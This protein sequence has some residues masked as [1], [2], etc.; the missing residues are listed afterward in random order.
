MVEHFQCAFE[1]IFFDT[2]SGKNIIFFIALLRHHHPSF[3][4]ERGAISLPPESVLTLAD[5]VY[6][7]Y[8]ELQTDQ[9]NERKI[10][11]ALLPF[12]NW[13]WNNLRPNVL[14]AG[15]ASW[16]IS[17]Y[18]TTLASHTH[19]NLHYSARTETSNKRQLKQQFLWGQRG[20]CSILL[21]LCL[22]FGSAF[23]PK[24]RSVLW[25]AQV[26]KDI[27]ERGCSAECMWRERTLQGGCKR[28]G[29][30][31]LLMTL[32]S[33]DEAT[34]YRAALLHPCSPV[35]LISFL[36]TC[37]VMKPA[38]FVF[39]PLFLTSHTAPLCWCSVA[40][41]SGAK[42]KLVPTKQKGQGSSWQGFFVKIMG[43]C[44]GSP[45]LLPSP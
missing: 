2:H 8:R 22:R 30:K 45:N 15:S 10:T 25:A 24:E 41:V 20:N 32:P 17:P 40:S 11:H 13:E 23:H 4:C 9:E 28:H 36:L 5:T 44:F 1:V 31:V 34:D 29:L 37:F 38:P 27:F 18:A 12:S 19:I 35:L 6:L 7:S 42:C 16:N 21:V 14:A 33:A 26:E 43:P 3:I 39:I